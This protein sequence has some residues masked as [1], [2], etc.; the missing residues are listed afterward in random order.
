MAV[1]LQCPPALNVEHRYELHAEVGLYLP[2]NAAAVLALRSFRLLSAAKQVFIGFKD[3]AT[4]TE[5]GAHRD[6]IQH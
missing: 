6:S 1:R 4:A 3:G 5:R 2:M